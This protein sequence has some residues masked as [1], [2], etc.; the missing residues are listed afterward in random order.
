[1]C[2]VSHSYS[3]IIAADQKKMVN[4]QRF[5]RDPASKTNNQKQTQPNKCF[6]PNMLEV[7]RSL[8]RWITK[9]TTNVKYTWIS[10]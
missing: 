8:H 10:S 5:K 1:M 6:P 7:Q 9:E 2:E 4:H 3:Y